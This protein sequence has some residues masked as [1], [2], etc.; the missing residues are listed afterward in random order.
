M[1]AANC[2]SPDMCLFRQHSHFILIYLLSATL[3]D[4]SAHP[5]SA[6]TNVT[7]EI[8]RVGNTSITYQDL[9]RFGARIPR[10]GFNVQVP[11]TQK[12]KS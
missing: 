6:T 4:L 12:K 11:G 5:M 3:V 1:E 2:K 7:V 8:R 9:P 10:P